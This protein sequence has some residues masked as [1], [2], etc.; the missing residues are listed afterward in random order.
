MSACQ[1]SRDFAG[2]RS[3]RWQI[4]EHRPWP[5]DGPAD[6]YAIVDPDDVENPYDGLATFPA[7]FAA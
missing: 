4:A 1:A 2:K 6:G 3:E 7:S 5:R